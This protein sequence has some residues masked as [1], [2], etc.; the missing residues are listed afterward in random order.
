MGRLNLR[1]A[2]ARLRA[3]GCV[4]ADDEAI[5]LA[6][7]VDD[8]VA[9]DALVD[10]RCAGEP[11][12]WIT[13]RVD[14]CGLAV[15]VDPGVYVPRW[16]T[17]AVASAA[18]DLLPS[19]GTALDLCC[20]SGAI[21]AVLRHRHPEAKI[22]ALDI[23]PAAVECA[24]RNGVDARVSDLFSSVPVELAGSVDVVVAV[25]PY[26]P[27]GAELATTWEPAAAIAGGSDG[28]RV[29]RPVILGAPQWL[30]PGGSLVVELGQP[31]IDSVARRLLPA[32]FAAMTLLRDPDG[33]L[34]GIVAEF[35]PRR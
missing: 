15:A 27:D 20:G 9:F 11:L 19:G 31:Q 2:E 33:D 29:L 13:G 10:R 4:A 8:Q 25:A 16:Q 24:R 34:C 3:A 26:V 30:R 18:A 35:R 6:A 17:E 23:D 1:G 22:M 5:A 28:L 21:A 14:F 32:G 12:A 7:I